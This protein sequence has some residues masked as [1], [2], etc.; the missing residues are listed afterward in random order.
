MTKKCYRY[1]GGFLEAQERWLNKMALSGYR[2]VRTKS[3]LYE[4]EECD[5]SKMHYLV[6]FIG[7][8]SPVNANDYYNFLVDLGYT[9]FYKNINLNYSIGKIRYRP[10][11]DKGGRISTNS[12]TFNKEILIV[13]KENDGSTF[14]LHTTYE[15]KARYYQTVR[16]PW[17]TIFLLFLVCGVASKSI[18]FFIFSLLALVP[19]LLY[20]VAIL[21]NKRQALTHEE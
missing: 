4:F 6:E 18:L 3:L 7:E 17:L 21:N 19:V 10:W 15:D 1:F 2:L 11:A 12:T 14:Q 16:N 8:K 13:G 20:Q 9:V 5:L